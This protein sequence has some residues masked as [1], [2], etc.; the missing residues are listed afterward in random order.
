MIC[1][2]P[3][4]YLVFLN[5]ELGVD[6][7]KISEYEWFITMIQN[8]SK[9]D[10]G[11]VFSNFNI[12]NLNW[13]SNDKTNKISLI[14]ADGNEIFN[15]QTYYKIVDLLRWL[16][17]L[18]KNTRISG[19]QNAHDAIIRSERKKNKRQQYMRSKNK[20]ESVLSPMVSTLVNLEGF[21]YD[22]SSVWNM[23]IYQFTD[24]IKQ[25]Q[26]IKHYN[27][28]MNGIYAG[29]ISSKDVNKDDMQ[30]FRAV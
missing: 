28:L 26:K 17:G 11:R 27:Q 7:E 3:S 10:I 4:D 13:A 18:E 15:E 23:H 29:T 19:N 8:I 2:T 12:D 30:L 6:W 5:D 20:C 25:M 1:S 21:K 16:H 24:A 14:D 9:E 22:Y